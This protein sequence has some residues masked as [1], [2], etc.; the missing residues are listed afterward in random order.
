MVTAKN[1]GPLVSRNTSDIYGMIHHIYN[2]SFAGVVPAIL[3]VTPA[4]P[5]ASNDTLLVYVRADQRPTPDL[6][7]WIM[8][9]YNGTSNYTL[10]L[11]AQQT[12]NVTQLYVSV[13]STAGQSGLVIDVADC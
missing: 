9:T 8:V 10:F 1:R 7:E 3:R 6:Y 12:I 11:T 4:M 2:L 5:P 13:Q